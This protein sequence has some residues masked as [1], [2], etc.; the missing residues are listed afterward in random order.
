MHA[1]WERPEVLSDLSTGT[2]VIMLPP[3]AVRAIYRENPG[4]YYFSRGVFYRKEPLGYTIVPAPVGT[5][6]PSLPQHR[7][8]DI[9]GVPNANGSYTPV[10]LQRTIDGS[11]YGQ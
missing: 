4:E 1:P 11:L 7:L 10:T 9:N 3:D 2:R 8:I 6:V 5:V